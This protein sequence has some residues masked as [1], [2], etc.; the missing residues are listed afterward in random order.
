M[1]I[2]GSV[3]VGIT[4]EALIE[5]PDVLREVAQS[6]IDSSHELA[7]IAAVTNEGQRVFD[8]INSLQIPNSV[9][10]VLICNEVIDFTESIV[11]YVVDNNINLFIDTDKGTCKEVQKRGIVSFQ[12]VLPI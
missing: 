12:I 11:Q 1:W 8:G 2:G 7:I 6:L 5:Y 3:K 9:I 4:K 10:S